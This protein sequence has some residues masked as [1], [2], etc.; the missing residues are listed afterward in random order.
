MSI[1]SQIH[2]F[3]ATI[4]QNLPD[5]SEDVMQSWIENP[6]TLQKLLA[7]LCPPVN[8]PRTVNLDWAKVYEALG[9]EYDSEIASLA[10]AEQEDLWTVPVIKG[11]T[12]NKV[13][14]GL[15]NM[16]VKVYTYID[17]LDENITVNDRDP[18]RD[19]SYTVSFHSNVEA[20]EEN[21]SQ[22]ANQRKEKGCKDITLLERL[23]LELAY[24]LSTGK[25]LDEEN[26]TLCAGS[27]SFVG[28][29][30]SVFWLSDSHKVY[31]SWYF[32]G[33]RD[34]YLRARSVV[35]LPV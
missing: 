11:L 19:G 33:I 10:I 32:S 25:H 12:C 15:R 34:R 23:L 35:S 3:G 9:T 24:F 30:P 5:V 31:V 29:V 28:R 14:A 16:G 18:N 21:R 13:V 17:D 26:W 6:R 2:K 4:L 22:S 27:R 7:G 20:D 1:Q 8:G